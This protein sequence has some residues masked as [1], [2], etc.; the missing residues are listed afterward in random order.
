LKINLIIVS[1]TKNNKYDEDKDDDNGED[2]VGDN[3][4]VVDDD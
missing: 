4:V 1:P 3:V 2:N